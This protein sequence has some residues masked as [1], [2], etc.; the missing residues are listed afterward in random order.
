MGVG[1]GR[2]PKSCNNTFVTE[3]LLLLLVELEGGSMVCDCGCC[4][5]GSGRERVGRFL[6][7][8]GSLICDTDRKS[9]RLNSSHP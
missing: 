3:L 1:K 9:T 7:E 5:E 2:F 8:M 4:W 6:E